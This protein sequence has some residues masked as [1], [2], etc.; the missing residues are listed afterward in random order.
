MSIDPF[1]EALRSRS[2]VYGVYPLDDPTMEQVT[3]VESHLEGKGYVLDNQAVKDLNERSIRYVVFSKGFLEE[4]KGHIIEFIDMAYGLCGHDVI[5]GKTEDVPENAIWASKS[6]VIYPDKLS[7][8]GVSMVFN[9]YPIS[10]IEGVDD[11]VA[12]NPSLGTDT[13]LKSKYSFDGP[14]HTMSTIVA[15]GVPDD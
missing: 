9:S 2:D 5:P 6:L 1:I 10:F 13:Y 8:K 11:A 4:P 7:D 15:L 14:K 3:D 12:Y